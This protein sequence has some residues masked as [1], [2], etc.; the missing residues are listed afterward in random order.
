MVGALVIDMR[1]PSYPPIWLFFEQ[2]CAQVAAGAPFAV[3]AGGCCG[4]ACGQDPAMSDARPHRRLRLPRLRLWSRPCDFWAVLQETGADFAMGPGLLCG[5]RRG[6]F[7][8]GFSDL[9]KCRR[10]VAFR[11]DSACETAQKLRAGFACI[12]SCASWRV[13]RFRWRWSQALRSP[14]IKDQVGGLR[15]SACRSST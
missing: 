5:F 3:G 15:W 7:A 2:G 10:W 8:V 12:G 6:P 9:G 13:F 4:L 11:A 14:V 1:K